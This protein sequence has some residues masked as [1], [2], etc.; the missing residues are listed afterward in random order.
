[1]RNLVES[2]F[3]K[4][5]M[6]PSHC[7]GYG[8]LAANYLAFIQFTSR[9]HDRAPIGGLISSKIAPRPIKSQQLN[10]NYFRQ[11]GIWMTSLIRDR[12]FL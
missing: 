12:R 4:D 11:I 5:Q 10:E 8:K 6:S 3:N 2:F 9:S 7:H 1:V